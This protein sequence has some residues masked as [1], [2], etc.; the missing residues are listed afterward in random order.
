M[1]NPTQVTVKVFDDDNKPAYFDFYLGSS[2]NT[3]A[4]INTAAQAI[5]EDAAPL[6]TGDIMQVTITKTLDITGWTLTPATGTTKNRMVG[7]R[8][9]HTSLATPNAKKELTLPTFQVDQF[10]VAGT[11]LIDIADATVSAFLATIVAQVY[12]SNQ[13]VELNTLWKYYET[14]GGKAAG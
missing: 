9:M 3:L 5:V 11:H 10:C 6:M 2:V 14:Y 4:A 8:F 7:G 13:D 12:S 1:A